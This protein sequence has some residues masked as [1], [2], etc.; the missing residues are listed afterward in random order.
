MRA[1]GNE[2]FVCAS[3]YANNLISG[4]AAF[5]HW[6]DINK[7]LFLKL[8][9]LRCKILLRLAL[10]AIGELPLRL[11]SAGWKVFGSISKSSFLFL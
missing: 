9:D 6:L 3:C 4:V 7:T 2:T 10:E 1:H 5:H 8:L 11:T